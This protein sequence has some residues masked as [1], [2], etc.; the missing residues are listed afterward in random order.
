MKNN[1]AIPVVGTTNL[2]NLIRTR[3]QEHPDRLAFTFLY[4]G[5]RI[6]AQLTYGEFVQKARAIGAFLQQ[7]E[8]TGKPVLLLHQPGL[9]YAAAFFGCLFAGAIAVPAY[10]PRSSRLASRIQAIIADTQTDL[11]LTTSTQLADLRRFFELVPTLRQGELIATDT[12]PPELARDWHEINLRSESLAYLQYTSGSI[13]APKGVMISHSNALDNLDIV[14]RSCIKTS[15]SHIVGWAPPYHDMG[16]VCG[17]LL[18]LYSGCDSTLMSPVAYLQRPFRWLQ[19]ISQVRATFS[20][21]PNFSYDLCVRKTTPE[22]RASLDLSCWNMAC[23]GAEPVYAQTLRRFAEAFAPCGFR[24]EALSPSYGMAE[25]TLMVTTGTGRTFPKTLTVNRAALEEHRVE[26]VQRD[27]EKSCELVGCEVIPKE[28]EVRVVHPQTCISCAPD[29]VGEIWVAGKSIGAGYW[30]KPE[31][32]AYTFRAIIKDTDE[33][34]FLRTGDLGFIRDDTLFITG[35]YKDVLIIRGRNLYPQDIEL[36]VEQSHPAIRP[37]CSA[38]FTLEKDEQEQ[39]VVVAEIDPHY[40]PVTRR[41]ERIS[42]RHLLDPEELRKRVRLEIWESHDVQASHILF[43]MVGSVPKTSSGKIQRRLC[44][45]L[46]LAG[47]MPLWEA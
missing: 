11:L 46:Y 36:T 39:L 22:Q 17:I 16:L 2:V 32:T 13:A 47:E 4:Q 31:E 12:I 28:L 41:D 7:K 19:A 1:L 44:R 10:P 35:R 26:L 6:E 5:E 18:P 40:Q 43:V 30:R 9:E 25:S 15:D 42:Y 45:Q 37:F 33:G 24:P 3:A 27:D 14:F 23:N 29:E 34:P 20:I 21:G 8:A 38:A